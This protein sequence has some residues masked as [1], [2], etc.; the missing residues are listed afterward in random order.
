MAIEHRHLM[1]YLGK[2]SFRRRGRTSSDINFL[3]DLSLALSSA[4]ET[5]DASSDSSVPE[6]GNGI[7][8]YE[9]VRRFEIGLIEE[10]L[11]RTGGR[12]R[13]AAVLLGLN[14]TTLNSKIKSYDIN[15]RTPFED[16]AD[17]EEK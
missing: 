13:P 16:Q 8:F 11:K 15:W 12:Q 4:L 6:I 5:L 3:R 10:A 9:E 2:D 7:D 14:A 17:G 1:R